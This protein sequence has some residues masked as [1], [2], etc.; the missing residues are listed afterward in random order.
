MKLKY[1]NK[2]KR[3]IAKYIPK[4]LIMIIIKLDPKD[5]KDKTDYFWQ[6]KYFKKK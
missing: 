4:A 1:K 5:L 3:I 2:L 6:L